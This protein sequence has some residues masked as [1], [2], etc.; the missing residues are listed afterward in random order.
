MGTGKSLTAPERVRRLQAALHAKAK[1]ASGYRFAQGVERW[2]GGLTHLP[3]GRHA[4]RRLRR[5]LCRKHKVR[6]GGYVRFPDRHLWEDLGLTRL[7]VRTTSFP[8]AKA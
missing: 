5:W 7:A 2:L 8:W 4:T 1:G 6:A 3:Q